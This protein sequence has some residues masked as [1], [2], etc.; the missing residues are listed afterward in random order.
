VLGPFRFVERVAQD[1]I[2]LERYPEYWNKGAIHL[3]KS[4]TCRSSMRRCGSPTSSP[5]S[6]TSSSG[7]VVGRAGAAERQPLPHFQD[8]R[9]RVQGITMNV[10]K[11]DLAKNNAIGKDR[12]CARPS[13]W[14][15]TATA[16]CRW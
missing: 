3:D 11:S 15:S 13:S 9:D 5:G 7:C 8:H 1:R 14:R 12:A 16:S 6:S 4:S 10:G 2:V